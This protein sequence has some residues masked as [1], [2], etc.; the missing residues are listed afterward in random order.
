MAVNTSETIANDGNSQ[1]SLFPTLAYRHPK[2]NVCRILLQGRVFHEAPLPLA[3]RLMLRGLQKALEI[4]PEVMRSEIFLERTRGFLVAPEA[5]LRAVVTYRDHTVQIRSKSRSNGLF[6][7][8]ADLPASVADELE[9]SLVQRDRGV[10][11][12][13]CSFL[14]GAVKCK[15]RVHFLGQRG[16]SVI[17]DIDDTIKYTLVTSRKQMLERT[18]LLPFEPIRGMAGRYQEWRRN[19]AIFHYVSSSPW[20][21]Q[22]SLGEFM[23]ESGFPCGSLHLRWFRLRDEMFKRWRV[24][25]RKSKSGAIANL[26]RRFPMRQF[27][28]VGDSGE[29]DPEIYAKIAKRFPD[30]TKAVLVRDLAER[31][32]DQERL[33]KLHAK[34]RDVPLILFR[35]AS[36]L[37]NLDSLCA[38]TGNA[39]G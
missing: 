27:V 17:S 38:L 9:A 4:P 26:V 28:L 6:F 10:A 14:E 32:V 25:R 33:D 12:I 23:S 37:P 24:V 29:R 36:E 20:Q 30:R 13:E 16:V 39:N 8:K 19:G 5:G 21:L 1:V 11:E 18:F 7:G 34:C 31:P 15:G 2:K 35:D 22:E 3:K